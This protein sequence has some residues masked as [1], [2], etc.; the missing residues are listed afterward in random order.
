VEIKMAISQIVAAKA[1]DGTDYD[2]V[3][4]NATGSGAGG[5]GGAVTRGGTVASNLLDNVNVY[6]TNETVFGSTVLDN[7]WANE[8]LSAGTFAYNNQS[9]VAKRLTDSLSGVSNTVLLSGAAVPANV[10]SIHKLETLRTRRYTAAIR[11]G[12]YNEYTGEF[13]AGFP[14]VAVDTLATDNAANPTRS[15]PGQLTYKG[16]ALLPVTNNDYKPKTG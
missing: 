14:V 9:P 2:T 10:R 15:A 11:A 5:N 6:R 1:S 7:D 16:G 4:P 12:K 13:D 3:P 8:A